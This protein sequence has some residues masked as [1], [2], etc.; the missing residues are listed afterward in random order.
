MHLA[1]VSVPRS[2]DRSESVL[3][4]TKAGTRFTPVATF[5]TPPVDEGFSDP[6]WS[7]RG[8]SIGGWWV[9]A[10]TGGGTYE[11][12][13]TVRLTDRRVTTILRTSR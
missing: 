8:D 5:P 10:T 9:F 4:T 3:V 6:S 1:A 2:Q 7:A 13:Y 12:L 11:R